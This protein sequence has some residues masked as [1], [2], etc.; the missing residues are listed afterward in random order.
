MTIPTPPQHLKY[1]SFKKAESAIMDGKLLSYIPNSGSG[2]E[3][4][5]RTMKE[6]TESGNNEA[7][8]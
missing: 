8:R 3:W 7:V 1:E 6:I 4:G 2:E 5:Y